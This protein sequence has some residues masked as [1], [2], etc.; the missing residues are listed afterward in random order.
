MSV[1]TLKRLEET[2][3]I[4]QSDPPKR[5]SWAYGSARH[6]NRSDNISF[7]VELDLSAPRDRGQSASAG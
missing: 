1:H 3:P 5:Q 2:I 6:L 4:Q 7:G